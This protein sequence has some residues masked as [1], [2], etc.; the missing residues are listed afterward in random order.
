ME[1]GDGGFVE[2]LNFRYM[3]GYSRNGS[4]TATL[5][6]QTSGG[7]SYATRFYGYATWG[8]L[9]AD[10]YGFYS[11]TQ[12]FDELRAS[13]GGDDD[14]VLLYDD[15]TRVDHLIVPFSGDADHD[16][17]KALWFNDRRKIYV[18]DFAL[19]GAF[20]SQGS[21]DGQEVAPEYNDK[22]FLYGD[23]AEA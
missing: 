16:P 2:A 3:Y 14:L 13:L 4:D 8:R 5:H 23:W 6:D 12:G 15:P 17:A 22:V 10:G 1:F 21:V 18:D 11:R 9:F 7:T 19:L 20:T